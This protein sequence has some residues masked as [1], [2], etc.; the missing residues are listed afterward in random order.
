MTT[1]RPPGSAPTRG[2]FAAGLVGLFVVTTI[3]WMG[4]W[5][6]ATTLLYGS[7]PVAVSSGSMAPA[8]DVGDLVVVE[9]YHGQRVR[10]GT[11]VVFDDPAGGR[12]TIHRVVEV[13]DDGTFTTRGDANP[14]ADSTPLERAEIDASGRF[15]LPRMGLPVVWAQQGRWALV[16]LAL[17]GLVL[18]VWLARFAL[19]DAYDPWLVGV[20]PEPG[21]APP[22]RERMT[23]AVAR[24][25]VS[26]GGPGLPRGLAQ[27]ARRRVA[28]VT[29]IALAVVFAH[30]T[31]TAYAAFADTTTNTG[32]QFAADTLSPATGL[33]AGASGCGAPS[34]IVQ[35]GSS[36]TSNPSSGAS[37]VITRPADA[38]VGHLLVAQVTF[39]THSFVGTITPPSG[40]TTIRVDDDTNHEMQGVFWKLVGASEPAS[41]T[42]TNGT[43]DTNKE[44]SGGIVA[45]AGV[46]PTTPIDAHGATVYPSGGSSITA[47]SLTTTVPGTQLL[48]LVGQRAN[49]PVAPPTG[50]SERF[51]V[52]AG[53][54]NL[55]QFSD[56]PVA[57]AGATGTRTAVSADNGSSVAQSVA[58]RPRLIN[59]VGTAGV[60]SSPDGSAASLTL[61]VPAGTASGDVMVAHVVL[62]THSFAA[63]PLPAPSGWT[64]VRADSDN[65]HVVAAVFW[66]VATGS[67][68]ASFTFTNNSGDTSQQAVGAIMAYRGVNTSAPIDAHAGT[69]SISGSDALVA[70]SVTTTRPNT[71]LL[72]FVGVYGNDQGP[73]TPP[74]SMNERYEATETAGPVIETLAEAAD[75][76]LAA[77]GAT[78]TRTT[79]V[80]GTE[81]SVTQSIAL[82]PDTGE[83]NADLAWTPSTSTPVDGYLVQRWIGGTLDNSATVTPGSASSFT[84]GPLTSGTTYTYRVIATAGSWQSTPAVTTFTATC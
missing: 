47:P 20:V 26:F 32:N 75:E 80:P 17:G 44:G 41:Y 66:R 61:P 59:S 3:G 12:S 77:P 5:A 84:D 9:P 50:M 78:G 70:P 16:L 49:G 24:V 39:H 55:A 69:P 46:D 63:N 37:L 13:A 19:L 48:T 52:S 65:N 64:R 73:A 30:A 68:P 2:R 22:V 14:V 82:R 31:V 45:F 53:T 62:H 36:T 71:R 74:P 79:S 83:A 18:A 4:L 54:Q 43:A 38:Q 7:A 33:S 81:T 67:E 57:A 28:E 6:A 25:R 56:Q 8:L 34:S 1:T 15:L 21:V 29:A 11:V 60:G 27:I 58:L 35:V 51:E 76:R 40:W 42:F 10:T 23:D 72:S